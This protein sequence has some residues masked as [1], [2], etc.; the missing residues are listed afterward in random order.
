MINTSR[1]A[2]V[3]EKPALQS[4]ARRKPLATPQDG[5]SR[6]FSFPAVFGPRPRTSHKNILFTIS[7]TPTST[8]KLFPSFVHNIFIMILMADIKQHK[9]LTTTAQTKQTRCSPFHVTSQKCTTTDNEIGERF[10]SLQ[11]KSASNTSSF[12]GMKNESPLQN[13]SER[14]TASTVISSCCVNDSSFSD[15]PD[16][17]E[18]NTTSSP[19][20]AVAAKPSASCKNKKPPEDLL[21][22]LRQKCLQGDLH[23]P[24]DKARNWE[25]LAPE[26]SLPLHHRILMQFSSYQQAKRER[27]RHQQEV[28]AAVHR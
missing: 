4:F 24:E 23:F 12:H 22:V 6:L 21:S 5:L 27:R 3:L 18:A 13:V 20:A 17:F 28:K 16:P 14:A 25:I 19:V 26:A 9:W 8:T 1:F 10:P 15:L 7:R 2:L 11:P